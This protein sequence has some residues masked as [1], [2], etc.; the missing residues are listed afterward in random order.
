VGAQVSAFRAEDSDDLARGHTRIWLDY[1]GGASGPRSVFCKDSQRLKLRLFNAF[2]VSGEVQFYHDIQP[3]LGVETPACIHVGYDAES[4]NSLLIFKDLREHGLT[5]CTDKTLVTRQVAEDQI[6]H[7]AAVHARFWNEMDTNPSMTSLRPFRTVYDSVN[8]IFRDNFGAVVMNGFGAASSAI[9]ESVK[10]RSEEVWPCVQ[11][12]LAAQFAAPP[13]LT[14]NDSHIDNWYPSPNDGLLRLGDWQIVARGDLS[15]DLALTMATSPT[16]DDR[17][18]WERDLIN[19]YIDELAIGRGPRLTFNEIWD[20]Y[21][22][23]LFMVLAWWTPTVKSDVD[24][25]FH[26][27]DGTFEI[28]RRISTAI[29]DLDAFDSYGAP[30]GRCVLKSRLD[31]R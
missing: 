25:E 11:R 1:A 27:R 5:F 17:R 30:R 15:F 22:A 26:D 28:I 14:H 19:L 16:I 20:R 12:A 4:H 24:F 8:A 3:A 9:P 7:I 21:R 2:L 18:A 10:A 23:Q 13:T 6:R 31:D 29:D